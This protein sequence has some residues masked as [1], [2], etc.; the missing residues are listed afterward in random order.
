MSFP[1]SAVS[2]IP[3]DDNSNNNNNE[4]S[5][6]PIMD[7][8][9][10][11][12]N[13]K[14]FE[15][16]Y[17][18][19]EC[20]DKD[21]LETLNNT[22]RLIF[23]LIKE[24]LIE[25]NITQVP[26]KIQATNEHDIF[27][28]NSDENRQKY[29]LEYIKYLMSLNDVEYYKERTRNPAFTSIDALRLICKTFKQIQDENINYKLN[30]FS[31]LP[32]LSMDFT[33]IEGRRINQ[34]KDEL[35]FTPFF[36][37]YFMSTVAEYKENNI[38][39]KSRKELITKLVLFSLKLNL[40]KYGSGL[41]LFADKENAYLMATEI[42]SKILNEETGTCT[43]SALICPC[44]HYNL[45]SIDSLL[46]LFTTFLLFFSLGDF[47]LFEPFYYKARDLIRSNNKEN[48]IPHSVMR[49]HFFEIMYQQ[50]SKREK[51]LMLEK[52]KK[53][54][55]INERSRKILQ[56]VSNFNKFL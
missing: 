20:F 17:T 14:S 38:L 6:L 16:V 51:E 54:K 53:K 28:A 25:Q 2:T 7:E 50:Q 3:N 19:E 8:F 22:E 11:L 18:I 26:F 1:F 33:I 37:D 15:H 9:N 12:F 47:N 45:K 44:K 48:F 40:K 31:W 29:T 5:Y 42:T 56:D 34:L 46:E 35:T 21:F 41:C 52:K 10:C 49:A 27:E 32:L 13:N 4:S 23:D 24:T 43:I 55:T 30:L 36:W 39:D